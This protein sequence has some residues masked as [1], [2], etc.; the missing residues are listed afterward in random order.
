MRPKWPKRHPNGRWD[1][2]PVT[3][4][5]GS[6]HFQLLEDNRERH[7]LPSTLGNTSASTP[8]EP[9]V[10]ALVNT[11]VSTP[12]NTPVSTCEHSCLYYCE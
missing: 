6:R 4:I 8:V 2:H 10:S 1:I 7:M 11:V 5:S 3:G 12:V 9:L